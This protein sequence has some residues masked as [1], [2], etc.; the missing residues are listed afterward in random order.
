MVLNKNAKMEFGF[1]DISPFVFDINNNNMET[2]Q[3][4]Y[5]LSNK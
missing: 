2:K 5:R 4:C 3:A 1:F